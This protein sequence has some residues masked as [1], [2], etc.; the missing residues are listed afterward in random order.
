M[1]TWNEITKEIR[2]TNDCDG[3]RRRL[4]R[5]LSEY[6]DRNTIIYVSDFLEPEKGKPL[7]GVSVDLSDKSGFQEVIENLSGNELDVLIE[8]PGGSPEAAESI[9]NLL[10]GKFSDIRFIIPNVAKSAATMLAL[11]GNYLVMDNKSELGPTDPQFI[12][13]RDGNS[14]MA[15]AQAILDQFKTANSEITKNPSCLP[16]WIPILNQ[17]GPSLLRECENAIDLTKKLVETWL[18][19]YM[20]KD[21]QEREKK[22]EEIA[23]TFASNNLH[24]SHKK[25]IGIEEIK[26]LGIK[27]IDM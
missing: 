27:V 25:M 6:T 8:S 23:K 17:Y 3:V 26:G 10:R 1:P 21:E 11:S 13:K 7:G 22:A 5:E 14:I 24:L 18:N 4:I 16:A 19:K 9:V 15:P 12:F 20:F 2:R